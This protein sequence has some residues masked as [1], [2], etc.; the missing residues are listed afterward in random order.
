MALTYRNNCN[1]TKM[2]E[3]KERCEILV[4]SCLSPLA[5]QLTDKEL[6]ELREKIEAELCSFLTCER[7][8]SMESGRNNLNIAAVLLVV[9]TTASLYLVFVYQLV[10]YWY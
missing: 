10:W 5:L 7:Y 8:W 2:A 1:P 9:A 4:D 3:L 6:L